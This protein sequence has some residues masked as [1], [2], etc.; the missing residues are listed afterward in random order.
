MCKC[1]AS[2]TEQS[3]FITQLFNFNN[4]YKSNNIYVTALLGF[5]KY[6]YF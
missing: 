5:I 4:V 6:L 3:L 2:E 1:G